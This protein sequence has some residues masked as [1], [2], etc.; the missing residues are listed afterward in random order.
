MSEVLF[1]FKGENNYFC[2]SNLWGYVGS[3]VWFEFW[4]IDFLGRIEG[5]RKFR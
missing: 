3:N 1:E 5:E 2:V 4:E